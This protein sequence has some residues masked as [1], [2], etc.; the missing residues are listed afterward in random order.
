MPG[1]RAVRSRAVAIRRRALAVVVTAVAVAVWWQWRVIAPVRLPQPVA[2]WN[3]DLFTLYYPTYV[4]A[5][6]GPRLL[7]AWNPDQLAGTPILAGYVCGLLYPSRLLGALMPARLAIGWGTA[8]DLALGVLF[9]L[10]CT[11]GLRLGWAAGVVAAVAFV[12][13]GRVALD[14]LRPSYF[15]GLMWL[16]AVF[17]AAAV[18]VRRPSVRAGVL[19]GVALAFQ[20]MTGHAQ[21]VCYAA[22]GV[23]VAA[24]AD[25]LQRRER[26]ARRLRAIAG[27]AALAIAVAGALAAVQLLPTAELLARATRATLPIQRTEP[28]KPGVD[29]LRNVLLAGGPAIL[30]VP[31][32]LAARRARALVVPALALVAFALLVGLDTPFYTDVFYPWLP[33]GDRFRWPQ[34]IDALAAF[35]LALLAAVGLDAAR[36]ETWSVRRTALAAAGVI[37]LALALQPA[38]PLLPWAVA[39]VA[40]ALALLAAPWPRTRG[41]IA[42]V[43]ALLALGER[44]THPNTVMMPQ[45]QPASFFAPPPFVD[46]LRARAPTE[47]VLAVKNWRNRW[48]VTE[49]MGSAFGLHVVQDYEPLAPAA[50]QTFLHPLG[51]NVDE[52]LFWGRIHPS[53]A[54]PEWRLLDLL[55]VRHVVVA[56]GAGWAGGG[57][58]RFRLVHEDA[59]AR[60]YENALALPRARLLDRWR[61]VPDA[62]AALATVHDPGFDARGEAVLESPAPPPPPPAADATAVGT[63]R[64]VADEPDVVEVAVDAARPALLVLADLDYPGWH[65]D[66]DGAERPV[67]R[68][69]Y[70]LRAVPVDAGSHRVR[71]RYVPRM[72]YAG[73]TI[74]AL[75]ALGVVA[76]LRRPAEAPRRR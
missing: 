69:D 74:S 7:P 39:T 50:Y 25:L 61:V 70:L 47:R 63:A 33:G 32:A 10:V 73:A 17:A 18:V 75:A 29:L 65:V 9:T 49:M 20:V 15:A 37:A 48:P 46:V 4:A 67:L 52:P 45:N 60:V 55:A 66:V 5:Y 22:Y 28:E 12:L 68:A 19:L 3:Q 23:A 6:G 31:L 57:L 14:W 13:H 26:D 42:V 1:V 41:A 64:I 21:I 38:P 40:A 53:A 54:S 2:T 44:A 34:E 58:P 51:G 71:F 27:A 11:R 43:V 36:R 8:L 56:A 24:A 30:L 35:A 59:T 72:L 16:P 76:A 62:S